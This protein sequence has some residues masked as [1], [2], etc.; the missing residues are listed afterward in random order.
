MSRWL[1][2]PGTHEVELGR[3]VCH[4]TKTPLRATPD[5]NGGVTSIAYRVPATCHQIRLATPA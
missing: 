4:A 5:S 3:V 2:V 1:G